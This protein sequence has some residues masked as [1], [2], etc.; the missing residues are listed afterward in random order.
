M[1][2]DYKVGQFYRVTDGLNGPFFPGNFKV[3]SVFND[4]CTVMNVTGFYYDVDTTTNKFFY[5]DYYVHELAMVQS[6]VLPTKIKNGFNV[7]D[8]V[9]C[10]DNTG[11]AN[12]LNHT[13]T[14]E[15]VETNSQ[16]LRVKGINFLF[17]I[18]RFQL[19]ALP[20]GEQLSFN[21]ASV[22]KTSPCDCGGYSTYN[23]MASCYHSTWCKGY[24]S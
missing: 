4:S 16:E 1:K 24:K 20:I 5:H 12:L 9:K 19:H 11:F 21:V 3:T 8:T 2:H 23:S 18:K 13:D 15:V 17:Y 22:T 6:K 10:I 14:Y 7:G